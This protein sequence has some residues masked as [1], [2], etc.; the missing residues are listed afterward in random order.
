MAAILCYS[1]AALLGAAAILSDEAQWRAIGALTI[2][3]VL[4]GLFAGFL[5]YI[6][7][8]DIPKPIWLFRSV[9]GMVGGIGFGILA[10]MASVHWLGVAV[11]PFTTVATG[12]LAG[13][14]SV[15]VAMLLEPIILR[16]IEQ[17]AQEKADVMGLQASFP[18]DHRPVVKPSPDTVKLPTE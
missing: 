5:T 1:A 18:H 4:G 3:A 2:G 10:L 6:R 13:W 14:L 17:K 9:A 12:I 15:P 16:K 8:P 11:S 7:K